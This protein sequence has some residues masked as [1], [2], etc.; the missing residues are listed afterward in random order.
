M[1]TNTKTG[2]ARKLVCSTYLPPDVKEKFYE[3]CNA[4]GFTP[5]EQLRRFVYEYINASH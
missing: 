2:K 1:I 5:A 3:K 4:K